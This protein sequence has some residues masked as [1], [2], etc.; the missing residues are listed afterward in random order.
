M[1]DERY[2]GK[3]R[4]FVIRAVDKSSMLHLIEGLAVSGYSIYLYPEAGGG[5]TLTAILEEKEEV[6]FPWGD[7]S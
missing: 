7:I 4:S 3:D 2:E 6:E 1:G 5:Y